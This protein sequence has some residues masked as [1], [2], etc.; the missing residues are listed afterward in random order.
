MH[1][2]QS[3]RETFLVLSVWDAFLA[4]PLVAFGTFSV[5]DVL[6][7]RDFGSVSHSSF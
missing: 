1:P 6:L 5:L 3:N 4:E 2:L 7:V